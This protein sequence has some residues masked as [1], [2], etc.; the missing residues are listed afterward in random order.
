MYVQDWS[1]VSVDKGTGC[2]AWQPEFPE[3]PYGGRKTNS[4]KLSPALHSAHMHAHTQH[5]GKKSLTVS[6]KFLCCL[7][8]FFPPVHKLEIHQ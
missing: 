5:K 2:S 7:K 6:M 1:D 4:Y 3:F 8:L